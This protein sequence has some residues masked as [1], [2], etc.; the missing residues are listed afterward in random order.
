MAVTQRPATLEALQEPSGENPL[1]HSVP[2]WFLVGELDRNI[3]A[4]LQR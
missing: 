2:S 4:A 3:P 1:W